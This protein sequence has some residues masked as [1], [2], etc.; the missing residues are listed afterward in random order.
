MYN[1]RPTFDRIAERAKELNAGHIQ[2]PYIPQCVP[3]A[4]LY[5]EPAQ[6]ENNR[7]ARQQPVYA[8]KRLCRAHVNPSDKR[9]VEYEEANRRAVPRGLLEERAEGLFDMCNGAKE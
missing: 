3:H 5:V 6:N 8:N 2:E 1:V 4:A 7:T 9:E